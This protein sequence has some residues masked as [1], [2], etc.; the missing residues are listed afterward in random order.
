MKLYMLIKKRSAP[1]YSYAYYKSNIYF[2][3]PVF[4]LSNDNIYYRCPLLLI[5][6]NKENLANKITLFIAFYLNIEIRKRATVEP[7]TICFSH[8]KLK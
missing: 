3:F 2:L 5:N 6:L 8:K 7:T 1:T 4:S